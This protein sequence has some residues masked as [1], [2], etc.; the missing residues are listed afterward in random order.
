MHDQTRPIIL[1][2]IDDRE[3][4]DRDVRK[5]PGWDRL[6]DVAVPVMQEIIKKHYPEGGEVIRAVA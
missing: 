1:V 2:F 6:A 3:W 4:P 5:G